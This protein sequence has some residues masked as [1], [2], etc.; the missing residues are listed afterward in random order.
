MPSYRENKAGRSWLQ[1]AAVL[2]AAAVVVKLLGTVQKIPLQN[3]AGDAAFGIYNA[4]YPFFQLFVFAVSA[5]VPLAVSKLAAESGG[6]SDGAYGSGGVA[7]AVLRAGL[8]LMGAGGLLG[9]AVLF[10][11]APVFAGWIGYAA[12]APALQA[13]ALAVLVMPVSAVFRGYFQGL[14]R[15]MASAAVQTAEQ[16]VRVAFIIA[17]L[18]YGLRV[19]AGPEFIASSAMGGSAVGGAAGLLC[20]YALYKRGGRTAG[21]G[22]GRSAARKQPEAG[23]TAGLLVRMAVQA[24]PIVVGSLLIPLLLFADV[25]LVMRHSYAEGAAGYDAMSDFG[26]FSRGQTLMQLVVMLAGAV[27]AAIV[28]A[29]AE[30]RAGSAG[31]AGL[32][33]RDAAAHQEGGVNAEQAVRWTWLFGAAAALGLALLAEPV[34]VLLFADAKGTAAVVWFAGASCFAALA[35]VTAALLQGLGRAGIPALAV[36]AALLLKVAAAAV[37]L[38]LWG[39]A[40]AAA[41]TAIALAAAA[42]AQL[43]ALKRRGLRLGAARTLLRSLAPCA[44]MA[45][46]VLLVRLLCEEAVAQLLGL[47]GR[48]LS[49]LICAV[50]VPVGAAVFLRTAAAV[51]MMPE[52]E[53]EPLPGFVKRLIIKLNR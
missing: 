52:H 51:G 47:E 53:L 37:L 7:P 49:A 31:A 29:L 50:G 3:F 30:D 15:M 41:A 44:S 21:R 28:P 33:A 32:D 23:R 17:L 25:F 43:A 42:A 2:G 6:R 18:F 26:A 12:A 10:V 16:A 4:V 8:W 5:G 46:A 14:D 48:A 11:A 1:G 38:P 27:A 13:A 39:I 24:L 22:P 45:A 35:S 20:A 34:N 36:P 19:A 40:A 9:G